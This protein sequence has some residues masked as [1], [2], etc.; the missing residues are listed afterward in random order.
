MICVSAVMELAIRVVSEPW[1]GS[2]VA[3]MLLFK[4]SAIATRS[5]P[6]AAVTAAFALIWVRLKAG[7]LV[8][9]VLSAVASVGCPVERVTRRV[10]ASEAPLLVDMVV[11]FHWVL[12]TCTV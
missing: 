11:P 8:T 9:W 1:H 10:P 6:L 5:T 2:A 7:V 3:V 12:L 4:L